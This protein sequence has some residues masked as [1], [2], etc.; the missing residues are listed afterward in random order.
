VNAARWGRTLARLNHVFVPDTKAGRDRVRNRWYVRIVARPVMWLYRSL[1]DEGRLLS[2]AALLV[3]GVGTEVL[4]T[5]IYLLWSLIAGLLLASLLLRPFFDARRVHLEISAPRQVTVGAE[6]CFLVTLANDSGREQLGL[7]VSRPL[8]PWDGTWLAPPPALAA[9]P[10]GARA[11][12]QTRAR[13]V[14]RGHHHLDPFTVAPLLPLG[15]A[16]GARGASEGFHFIAVPPVK[17]IGRLQL[18]TGSRYQPGGVALASRT[19]ESMDLLGVRPYRQGDAVRDLHA[20]SWAKRG[21]PVVREYQQEYFSRVGVILDTDRE[22][23][24]PES[25]E[26]ALSLAAGLVAQL[27]RGEALIDVLVMGESVHPLTLGRSLGYLEQALDHLACAARGPAFDAAVLLQRV[28]PYLGRLSSVVFIGLDWDASRRRLCEEIRAGGAAC[29]AF[30]VGGASGS[31]A[32][33]TRLSV[34]DI[35]APAALML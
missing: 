9:L 18:G 3:G 30:V 16:L 35:D 15:L 22:A 7:R 10:A 5:R 31:D 8:L 34:A 12:L 29:R 20:R 4:D 25:F 14:Q 33:V 6:L 27:S 24:S 13:F 32:E 11:P 1:S 2:V 28:G 17:A 21:E 19:G 23:G 26:A